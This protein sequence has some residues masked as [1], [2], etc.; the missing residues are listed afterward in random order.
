MHA[1]GRSVG[2]KPAKIIKGSDS[3]VQV[4]SEFAENFFRF[5]RSQLPPLYDYGRWLVMPRTSQV[6]GEV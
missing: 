4:L 2:K 1:G 3:I 6:R 5:L